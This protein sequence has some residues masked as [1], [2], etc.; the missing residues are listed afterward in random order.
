[1]LGDLGGRPA[2]P[3]IIEYDKSDATFPQ[4][5][6]LG[7]ADPNTATSAAAWAIMEVTKQTDGS[8]RTRWADGDDNEDNVWDDRAGLTYL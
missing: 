3:K 1:M 4:V 7:I 2:D 5:T 8:I 6:Y